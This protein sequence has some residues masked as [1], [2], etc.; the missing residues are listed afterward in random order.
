[1]IAWSIFC[2]ILR[3][4]TVWL[5]ARY[6]VSFWVESLINTLRP[7]LNGRHLPHDILKW[8]LLNENVW[9]L[10]KIS[11][12]FAPKVPVNNIPQLLQI[13]A[14]RCSGDK[15]LS[16]PIM[17]SLLTHIC[18]TRPQWVKVR[19]F[20]C[21]AICNICCEESWLYCGNWLL[22]GM[23]L[24]SLAPV[25]CGSNFRSVLSE[26]MLWI[27]FMSASHEI[28]LRLCLRIP[29][30]MR[31]HCFR[32]WPGDIR[33]QT[34]IWVNFWTRYIVL[35]CVTR[36]QWVNHLNNLHDLMVYKLWLL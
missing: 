6:S 27:K 12:K 32:Q 23:Y 34:I 13:M 14:W 35:F 22:W 10:I 15:P 30:M 17:V 28:T 18:L 11:L 19:H 20:C 9:L 4:D 33:Q 8:I 24:N 3:M 5:R 31:P 16:E 29:F 1:M 36:P 25:Q 7:R 26:H 2:K 21:S